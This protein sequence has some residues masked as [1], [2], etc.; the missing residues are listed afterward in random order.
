MARPLRPAALLPGT[1]VGVPVAEEDSEPVAV[2]S[3]PPVAEGVAVVRVVASPVVE[4][5][6]VED[7]LAEVVLEGSL[8]EEEL[9]SSLPLLPLTALM[10][11]QLPVLSV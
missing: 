3:S 9:S 8:E 2:E 1:E 10:L 7:S 6:L 5:A 11:C 4:G